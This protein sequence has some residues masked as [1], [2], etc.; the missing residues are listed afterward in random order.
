MRK[1]YIGQKFNKLTIIREYYV[2]YKAKCECL[3]ECGGT[4]ITDRADVI[5]GHT[6]SCGCNKLVVEDITGKKF[7]RLTV[8]KK[9][10]IKNGCT[11]WTCICDCDQKTI[12]D[13][14]HRNLINGDTVSC[15]CYRKE[16]RLRKNKY[17]IHDDYVLM[18]DTKGNNFL[19]DLE[20]LG[21]INSYC[22]TVNRG[23]VLNAKIGRLHRYIMNIQKG[24]ERVVDHINHIT[25]DNR[26]SNLRICTVSENGINKL[27]P[28]NNTSGRIGVQWSNVSK[29]WVA[30][31]SVNKKSKYLG[32]FKIKEEAIKAREEAEKKYYKEFVYNARMEA[33]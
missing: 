8:L 31:I 32:S 2:N 20:D 21:K 27:T 24:D 19:I 9:S 6:T 25:T 7:G 16:I 11:Y 18:Y 1:T 17:E 12:K 29:K 22:W 28:R 5:S 4:I 15:G 33:E 3:C 23:Y 30:T 13:I 10:K 14:M 26:K